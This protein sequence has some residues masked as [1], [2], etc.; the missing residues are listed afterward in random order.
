MCAQTKAAKMTKTDREVDPKDYRSVLGTFPTGV[1][2]MTAQTPDG[3]HGMTVGSF[4]S[5][6]LNPPLVAF[7]PDKSSS[8]FPQIREAGHFMVNVLAAEQQHVCRVFASR[9]TDRFET[10]QWT[11]SM[12]TG[13]PVIDGC[14]AWIECTIEAINE[15]GDHYIVIGRVLDLRAGRDR[16]PLVFHRGGYGG[17]HVPSSATA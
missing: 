2:I 9:S 1:A 4:T 12:A 6:S 5:V 17:F 8:S 15:A 16:A 14:L 11:P 13:A 7:F 10:V 3:P